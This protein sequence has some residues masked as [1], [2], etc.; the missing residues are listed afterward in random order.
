DAQQ[1]Q[2]QGKGA[3]PKV[4]KA[5]EDGYKAITDPKNSDPAKQAPLCE[6][7][8]TK[9]PMSRYLPNVYTDLTKDY[10][11]LGMEDK[12]FAAADKALQLNQ[13][14]VAVLAMM[15]MVIPRRASSNSL[16]A[17]QQLE[18]AE[19]YGKH[20]I[21]V[22]ATMTKPADVDDATFEKGKNESL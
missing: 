20:A 8:A 18:K 6:A 3:A 15:A 21:E 19:G 13:D 2:A 7:F 11:A 10:L 4:N 14:D 16:D 17:A 22:I 1:G 9:F 5:E 12:M